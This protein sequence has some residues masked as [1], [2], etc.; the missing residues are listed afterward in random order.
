MKVRRYSTQ[1]HQV[2]FG[3]THFNIYCPFIVS[4]LPYGPKLANDL[5]RKH[6]LKIHKLSL[7]SFIGG[8][9]VLN[10]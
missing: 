10:K 4:L 9:T 5:A 6:L 7:D 3:I 8:G 2:F 1:S